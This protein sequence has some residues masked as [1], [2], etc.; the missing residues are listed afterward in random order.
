M[1]DTQPAGP[2][3]PPGTDAAAAPSQAEALALL[4]AVN[5]HEVKAAEMAKSK[6]VTGPVLEYANMMQAEHGKNMT[7]TNALLQTAG[8]APADSARLNEQKA[9]SEA[10]RAQ[11]Q[12][13]E[14]EAFAKG[15]IDA[16]VTDHAEALTLLDSMLIPAATDEAVRNH[17]TTTRQHVQQHHDRAREIQTQLGGASAA[18]SNAGQAGGTGG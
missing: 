9:K 10:K 16:M 12:A 4:N 17:L 8:G 15:Y 18:A 7:D 3:V 6:N 2:A 11:L 5:D 1:T 13:L 14:G